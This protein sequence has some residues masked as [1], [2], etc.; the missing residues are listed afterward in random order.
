MLFLWRMEV[1]TLWFIAFALAM[2]ISK[3][4]T[5]KV[6]VSCWNYV[7]PCGY[8]MLMLTSIRPWFSTLVWVLLLYL[9][10]YICY[11]YLYLLCGN[12]IYAFI[13]QDMYCVW[14]L[15]AWAFC[16][17]DNGGFVKGCHLFKLMFFPWKWTN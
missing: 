9:F 3:A 4:K 16:A 6:S 11:Y 15:A 17:S 5:K 2:R 12:K 1:F 10:I 13:Y 8:H 14:C 7:D